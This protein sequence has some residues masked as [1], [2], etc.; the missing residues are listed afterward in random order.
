VRVGGGV[1]KSFQCSGPVPGQAAKASKKNEKVLDQKRDAFPFTAKTRT[2]VQDRGACRE[3]S[4]ESGMEIK[5]AGQG[6][7]MLLA[8]WQETRSSAGSGLAG[9]G[10]L[11]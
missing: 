6:Q 1:N 5:L 7:V 9:G 3:G 11:G 10:G 8:F 2:D 4:Q